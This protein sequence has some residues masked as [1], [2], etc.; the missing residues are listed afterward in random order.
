VSRCIDGQYQEAERLPW[1]INT[2]FI[3]YDPYVA[4]DESFLIFGSTR[5]GGYGKSDNYICFPKEDG[6]WIPPINLGRPLNSS[7]WDLCANGTPDGNYFLFLSGR[8]TGVDKGD[9]GKKSDEEPGEDSDLYWVDISFIDDLKNTVLTRRNAAEIINHDY[10]ENGI[11]SAVDTLNKLYSNQIDATY[12][13]PFELLSLCKNMITK[14]NVGN[15]DLF[16]S[17]LEEVLSEDFSIKEG[18]AIVCAMN[19]HVTKG[20]KILEELESED[21]NFNLSDSLSGLGYLFTL[22]PDKTEDALSVL[23]FTVEKFPED[24]FA[25]FSLARV[26]RRLG[27]LD[28]AIE[29]CRKALEIRPSVGDISQLLERLLHEQKKK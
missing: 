11:Q 20:L 23:K 5:P 25:Y 21:P 17:A 6:S 27:D 3:E 7:S 10:R 13:S 9:I 29:N 8:K 19:G 24:P 26:Y 22:Y 4:P 15:A 14:E 28:K 12:F 16:F 1:P 2:D 18:Y